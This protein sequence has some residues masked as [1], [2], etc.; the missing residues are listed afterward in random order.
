MF[1]AIGYRL[2]VC[3]GLL[4]VSLLTACSSDSIF[5]GKPL[6]TVSSL[7]NAAEVSWNDI[8][9]TSYDLYQSTDPNCDFNNIDTCVG[10]IV[11]TGVTSPVTVSSLL[12]GTAYYFVVKANYS[13][14]LVMSS[15][16]GAARPDMLKTD[17]PVNIIA[18]DASNTAYLGGDFTHVS[19]ISGGGVPLSTVNSSLA[20]NF[21]TVAGTVYTAVSDGAGGWYIGG[22]FSTVGGVARSNLAHILADGSLDTIWAPSVNGSVNTLAVSGNTV[23]VGGYFNTVN[24]MV[25]SNLAAIDSSGT[26]TA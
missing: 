11:T 20:G 23:Y 16:P 4:S 6:L 12:K 14:G 10:G 25:R 19:A 22:L 2:L 5:Y 18:V 21:P 26:L 8:G 3:F 15:A 9:A 7:F 24:G 17:G 1:K 13:G